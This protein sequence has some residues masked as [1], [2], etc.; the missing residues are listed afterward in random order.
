MKA[1]LLFIIFLIA[2]DIY[3]LS[4]SLV[5]SQ[6][7]SCSSNINL[8][9]SVSFNTTSLHCLSVWDSQGFI[10][11]YSQTASNLWSFVLS[12]PDTTSYIAMGF[13]TNGAMVGSSAIV[14]WVSSDGAGVVKQYHLGGTS[15]R[16]VVPDQG[17]L[18]VVSNSTAI[19]SQSLRLYMAFQLETDNDQQPQSRPLYSVGRTGVFPSAPNYVLSEHQVKVST[20]INYVTGQSTSSGGPYVKLR[21]SHG[22]LNMIGWG[23]LMII[24]AIVARYFKQKDPTWFYLHTSIQLLGFVLG[25]IGIVCGFILKN[26]LNA[27]VSTHKGIG[28]FILVLGCL[29][30]MAF[31]ARP[32]KEAKLRKYWNWYH[33]NVGRIL[34]IFTI[35]NIFYGIHLGGEGRGWSA[36]Y[37]VVLCVLFI[38]IVVLELRSWIRK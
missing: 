4:S 15:P 23:I 12:A 13:S 25:I 30:V 6:T 17:N 3:G 8:N 11:R 29:Q 31:L 2:L 32:N 28:I 9:G 14:G 10:L 1:S 27:H 38:T 36:G 33:Q 7:E 19:I 20:S 22:V 16:L 18:K 35:A 34:I 24:G 37:G 21:R 26:R 5:N